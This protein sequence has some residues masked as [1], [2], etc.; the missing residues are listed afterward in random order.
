MRLVRWRLALT[1]VVAAV[2]VLPT[3]VPT[4]AESGTRTRTAPIVAD[5]TSGAGTS[6]MNVSVTRQGNLSFESPSGEGLAFDGY[7]LCKLDQ[8]QEYTAYAYNL[9]LEG[10]DQADVGFGPISITQPNRGAFPVTI[11]RKTLDGTIRLSQTVAVPDPT[12]KEV[13]ITMTVR[14][15]GT[16]P[17]SGLRLMRSANGHS[18]HGESFF[19]AAETAD[20][21]F[22]WWDEDANGTANGVVM[23][24]RT[25]GQPHEA[26]MPSDID[27]GL[28]CGG[29]SDMNPYDNEGPAQIVY[30]LPRLAP[31]AEVTRAFL[32]HRL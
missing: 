16:L 25:V 14:N 19:R 23:S 21:V 9:P 20:S 11:V 27:L 1:A 32:Y 15:I 26:G 31:G 3:T 7:G 30:F 10:V 12:D 6:Y 24:A 28:Y 18:Q 22:Q 5:F 8:V 2:L 17:L 4:A 13:T 29:Y